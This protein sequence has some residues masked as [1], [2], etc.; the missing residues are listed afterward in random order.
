MLTDCIIRESARVN[1]ASLISADDGNE[2]N[3]LY[4]IENSLLEVDT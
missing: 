1:E 3:N 4:V 2:Q